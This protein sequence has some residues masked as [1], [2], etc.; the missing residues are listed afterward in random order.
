MDL[1]IVDLRD[2]VDRGRAA[3]GRSTVDNCAAIRWG[4]AINRCAAVSRRTTVGRW[5]VLWRAA[6]DRNVVR[7]GRVCR[8]AVHRSAAVDRCVVFSIA[9]NRACICWRSIRGR[10]RSG[11]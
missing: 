9:R 11:G 1:A 10:R 6:V 4:A 2:G 5:A 7:I 3:V 8:S